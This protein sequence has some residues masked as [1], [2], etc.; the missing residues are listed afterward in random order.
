MVAVDS[1]A[2]QQLL[3]LISSAEAFPVR[4]KAMY[5]ISALLR[6]FPYAQMKFLQLGGLSTFSTLFKETDVRVISLKVKAVTLLHDML[7]EHVS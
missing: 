5:A 6:H 4:K 7:L 2:L 1:G 3:H